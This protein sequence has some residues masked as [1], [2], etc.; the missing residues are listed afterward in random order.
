MAIWLDTTFYAFDKAI[1][2][3]WNSIAQACGSFLTPVMVF[4]SSFGA[5]GLFMILLSVILTFFKSTRK[6]GLAALIAII[7]GVIITNVIL[8]DLVARQRPY[9]HDEYKAWWSLV[10][11]HTEKEFAFPS[12]HATIAVDCF[13]AFF[14]VS[15]KKSVSWLWILFAVLICA[16]RNYLMVHYP[17]DVLAGAL[18]GAGAAIVGTILANLIY[19]KMQLKPTTKFNNFMLNAC[20]INVF[21]KKK[22]TTTTDTADEQAETETAITTQPDTNDTG[23]PDA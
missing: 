3:F 20:I 4:I 10:G 2:G 5:T 11:E 22:S 9:T 16:S 6:H 18:I 13:L 23:E 14:L 21:R 15:K 7:I 12:G 17:T 8:K 19:K 1:L